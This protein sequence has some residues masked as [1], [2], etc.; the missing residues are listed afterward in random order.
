MAT[1]YKGRGYAEDTPISSYEECLPVPPQLRS[2]L[3]ILA[4]E[5]AVSAAVRLKK[6]SKKPG[7]KELAPASCTLKIL[8]CRF[9]LVTTR[10]FKCAHS[11]DSESELEHF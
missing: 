6:E 4:E 8:L 1:I 7:K 9:D 5:K 11:K 10:T 3:I 2:A